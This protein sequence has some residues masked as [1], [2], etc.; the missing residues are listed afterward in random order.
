[1]SAALPVLLPGAVFAVTAGQLL[2]AQTPPGLATG[3]FLHAGHICGLAD[4]WT[5]MP[6]ASV[7]RT[8]RGYVT[9]GLGAAPWVGASERLLKAPQSM[10]V[11]THVSKGGCHGHLWKLPRG[12]GGGWLVSF[13]KMLRVR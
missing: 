2:L 1:M 6:P 8:R 7:H 3:G 9:A 13:M 5:V 10:C 12:L 11:L 4:E